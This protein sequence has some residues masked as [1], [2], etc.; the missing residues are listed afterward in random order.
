MAGVILGDYNNAYENNIIDEA[1]SDEVF[2]YFKQ[3]YWLEKNN[4]ESEEEFNDSP[5]LFSNIES[6]PIE[7]CLYNDTNIIKNPFVK[8]IGAHEMYVAENADELT[9]KYIVD[10]MKI[11]KN[12]ESKTKNEMEY[13][14][15]GRALKQW[16]L[17]QYCGCCTYET[18]TDLSES[19]LFMATNLGMEFD[20]EKFNKFIDACYEDYENAKKTTT[21]DSSD[22]DFIQIIVN[23][24]KNLVNFANIKI[25]ENI[26]LNL[27]KE[28]VLNEKLNSTFNVLPKIINSTNIMYF[29]QDQSQNR[30]VVEKLGF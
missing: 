8:N 13:E 14:T 22:A 1:R 27:T 15:N 11:L 29:I 23:E 4:L 21:E 2:Q 9:S 16:L 12:L 25:A 3:K 20:L 5:L 30:D 24:I 7:L 10:A 6:L 17:G 26:V 18:K 19:P 28:S